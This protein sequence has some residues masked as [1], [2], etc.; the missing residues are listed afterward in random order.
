MNTC[1]DVTAA[2]S[3]LETAR[4]NL[5]PDTEA[6]FYRALDTLNAVRDAHTGCNLFH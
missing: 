4:D 2:R 6:A 1:Q 5:G 3:A